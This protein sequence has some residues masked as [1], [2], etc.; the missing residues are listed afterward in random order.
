MSDIVERLR[1]WVYTDSL[2]ATARE[3]ADEIERLRGLLSRTGSVAAK[4]GDD[5][6]ECHSK[7]EKL[8]ERER[9]TAAEREAVA[10]YLGTGGP[11]RVDATLV[12]MLER[13]SNPPTT[14]RQ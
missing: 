11:Y 14:D 9:L 13:L 10:Y 6:E 7:R 3:A 12:A 1:A 8:P 5:S 4:T 2:Y